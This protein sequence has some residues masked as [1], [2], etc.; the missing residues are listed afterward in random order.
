[1]GNNEMSKQEQGAV[2]VIFA[3]GVGR[4]MCN[5]ATPKQ[6]IKVDEVPILIHTLQVFQNHPQIEKIYLV[7]VATHLDYT[8]KLVAQY[9]ISKVA[10]VVPGGES[11][12]DSIYRGLQA[13][14]AENPADTVV[15]I[16]DG[17]RPIVSDKVI[18]A[19]IEA[20]ERHGAAATCFPS[21]ETVLISRDGVRLGEI[22][23]REHVYKAQAPQSFYLG[24]IIAAHD[25]L[26]AGSG[27]G[28]LVDSCSVY[29]AAGGE[30]FMVQ[31]NYG[32]IKVTR[33][34]DVYILKGLLKYRDAMQAIGLDE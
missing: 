9:G 13:A 33:P 18:S 12:L 7:M 22:P 6:F 21:F 1:M 24:D 25:K 20:V 34:E 27:Y 31:G 3:G 23:T 15:L 32:N 8:A 11:G 4:R 5:D 16:H 19:N 30:V 26:R 2:A 10:A 14:R 17:V 28:S 29:R